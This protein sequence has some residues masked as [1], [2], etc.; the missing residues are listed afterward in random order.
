[1]VTWLV[2]D[3]YPILNVVV[4]KTYPLQGSTTTAHR[5]RGHNQRRWK[6]L[7]SCNKCIVR[8][9]NPLKPL[10][11]FKGSWFH[12]SKSVKVPFG[13]LQVKKKGVQCTLW[14]DSY[15]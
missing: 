1:M 7:E 13:T 4:F 5:I 11:P 6:T 14:V 8:F 3:T 15:K 9:P 12:M 10:K 2:D